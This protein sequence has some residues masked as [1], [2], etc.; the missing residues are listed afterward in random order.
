MLIGVA[1]GLIRIF[2]VHKDNNAE[3]VPVDMCVNSLLAAAWDISKQKKAILHEPIKPIEEYQTEIPIYNFVTANRNKCTWK[4]YIDHA[5]EIGQT[6]PVYK[7]IWYISFTSTDNKFVHSIL[8]FLYHRLPAFFMDLCLFLIGK[9]T[10]WVIVEFW[11]T[12]EILIVKSLYH[13]RVQE[14][15]KKIKKYSDVIFFFTHKKFDFEH[16]NVPKLYEKLDE[17]DKKLFNFDMEKL[18]W[19]KYV[20]DN[21]I[22]IRVILMKDPLST[23]PEAKK[24]QKLFKIAHYSIIYIFY[25]TVALF[26]YYLFSRLFL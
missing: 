12:N 1:A 11:G 19:K 3:V 25:A 9:K 21:V 15:Y 23:I 8:W 13:F 18:D 20:Q 22:G 4:Q 24:R 14:I 26:V 7:S 5:W 10:K 6:V 2:H 16:K 17:R